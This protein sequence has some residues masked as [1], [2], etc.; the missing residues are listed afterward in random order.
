MKAFGTEDLAKELKKLDIGE[1]A[2]P[3]QRSLGIS[4]NLDTDSFL[5]YPSSE[6][7]PAKR[8]GVLSTVNSIFD[9][10]GFV[11]PIT[12]QGKLF[13]RSLIRSSIDWDS[14]LTDEQV[15]WWNEWRQS[16]GLL[17]ELKIPRVYTSMSFASCDSKEVH[18]YCDA[19]EHGIAAVGYLLARREDQKELGF[20][21][22]KAKVAPSHGHT[23]PRL[24]LCAAVLSTEIAQYISEQLDIDLSKFLFHSDSKVVLGYITNQSRRFYTYV[25]N[26][27][28]RIRQVTSP[29]QWKY[30]S[31]NNNPADVATRPMNVAD[32]KDSM[33]LNGPPYL[34]PCSDSSE[35][36][37]YELQNPDS[38]KEIRP[39]VTCMKTTQ[40]TTNLSLGS[41]RFSE[42]SDW[43]KLIESIARLKHVAQSFNGLGPCTG[44]HSCKLMKSVPS[45]KE[46][47]KFVLKVVQRESY[48][49]EINSIQ[50]K[51]IV[52]L[53]SSLRKLD[54]YM[55]LDGVLRVGG[56]LN[57]G[58]LYQD[59]KNP[60]IVPSRHHV[61]KLIVEYYH[62]RSR[63]Q[64]RHIT[65]GAV[66]SAGFWI[67]GS[68]RLISSILYKC[69]ICRKL[70]RGVENQKMADLPI[71]RTQPGPPFTYVGLD[72]FGPWNIV[73]RR[74]R[75]G[76]TNSKRWAILFTCLTTRGVHIEVIEE[77]SASSFINAYRR[78]V[79]LRGPVKQIR[80]DRGTN[81]V[82]STSDLNI[83][84]I[85]VE[86]GP[87]KSALYD[88][89]TTWIFNPSH[90]SH[91]GG[92]WERLIGVA[93]R[94]L[95]S[96][97]LKSSMVK[98]HLTHEV[99][100]TFLA[101]VT[102]IMNSRPLTTMSTDPDDPYPLSPSL[103]IT[104]K[105]DVLVS[106]LDIAFDSK[107]MY[108]SQWKRV[109]HLADVFWSKW[110]A[111]YLQSLQERRKWQKEQRNVSVGDVVLMVDKQAPR[112][113]WPLGKVVKTFPSEDNKVHKA[114]I[115]I[116]RD[117]KTSTFIRPVSE[118]VLL[119]ENSEV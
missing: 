23:I 22:G 91:M 102:A 113:Q 95:D 73:T 59:D 36:I 94:I 10:L 64:G 4:W 24:E 13:L 118:F 96:M 80:S 68:K 88:N 37:L 39:F 11:A 14:P 106:P 63:H 49:E 77:M 43:K 53:D 66:R 8:R 20:I 26:R 82:G 33:W 15:T 98:G 97:L 29:N 40:V 86:D 71:D 7:K 81:F 72:A 25:S 99:L 110:K 85:S 1:G 78:F 42:F 83:N 62:R 107:D 76:V 90:S 61:A 93:R 21:L 115:R 109:R 56:R 31:T 103:L 28:A 45:Y 87:V 41:H 34:S 38:D 50:E 84:T 119:I 70:R 69:V 105:P 12:V 101:E 74:T 104:Q 67:V 75:G 100:V 108:R 30:V 48:Q 35:E 117:G 17:T 18:M 6:V 19:S 27:V 47:E 3:V 32:L 79:A 116:S 114:E 16:L 51:N 112:I 55:D 58:D 65:G 111:Q 52:P 44:W 2:L 5:F 46:T 92:V 57:R 60:I 89:G 9:P 54:P